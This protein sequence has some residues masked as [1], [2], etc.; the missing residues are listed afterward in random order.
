M[1]SFQNVRAVH[2]KGLGDERGNFPVWLFY[3][4]LGFTAFVDYVLGSSYG[5]EEGMLYFGFSAHP[6]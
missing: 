4:F 2:A 1:Q 6:A 3:R 5:M